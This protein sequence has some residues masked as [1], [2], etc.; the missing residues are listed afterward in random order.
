[1]NLSKRLQAVATLVD[2][3][4]RVIDVGCDHGYL[5]IYLKEVVKV[6]KIIIILAILEALFEAVEH[7][8]PHATRNITPTIKSL[9]VPTCWDNGNSI[10][11]NQ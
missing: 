1:M 3:N 9:S 5:S 6:K 4:S 2:V 8:N 10:R 11:I 7:N